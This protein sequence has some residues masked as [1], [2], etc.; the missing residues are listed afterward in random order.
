MK[1]L[2]EKTISGVFWSAFTQV[3]RQSFSFITT[4]FL[5]RLL[6]PE[7]FGLIGMVTVL[8]G[9]ATI[10]IDVGFGSAL[11]QKKSVS[12]LELSS[13]FWFNI[14]VGALL[15]LL[16]FTVAPLVADF[17]EQPLLFPLTRILSLSFLLGSFGTVQKTILAKDINFKAP[18][19]IQ[20]YVQP[21]AAIVTL[22]MAYY[23]WGVW[24]L[25]VQVILSTAL[26]SLALWLS[27]TWRPSMAFRWSALQS[28]FGFSLNLLGNDTLNYWVRN[29]DNLLVGRYLGTAELGIYS[30]SYSILTLPL[31]NISRVVSK[32]LFP[33]LARV[34]DQKEKVK[35]IYLKIIRTISLISFPLMMGLLVVSD[36]FVPLV[37]GEQWVS[38]IPLVQVFCVLGMFQSVGHAI[39]NLYLSQGRSDLMFRVGTVLRVFLIMAIVVGLRWGILGVAISY[40]T[41]SIVA[42]FV[43]HYYAGKLVGLSVREIFRYLSGVF[44]ASLFMGLVVKGSAYLLLPYMSDMAVLILQTLVG[45]GVYGL[46]LYVCRVEALTEVIQ[47]YQERRQKKQA[48]KMKVVV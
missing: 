31:R 37:Y 21:I 6:S 22:A 47:L 20:A 19:K 46:I 4:I 2:K 9:F 23:G 35:A 11:I 28:M 41:M 34:Q 16:F 36:R 43:D 33:S 26:T 45:A 48:R 18:F 1:N 10:F 30:K 25:V 5:V 13:V 40:T 42:S 44:F 29:V 17:Y 3:F 27:S 15:T 24:A 14:A 32:V 12:Q 7:A 38:M 39:S 8:T